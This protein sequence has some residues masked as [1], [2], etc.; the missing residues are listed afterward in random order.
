MTLPLVQSGHPQLQAPLP[1][2][3]ALGGP[4]G[5]LPVRPPS[6]SRCIQYMLMS[7]GPLGKISMHSAGLCPDCAEAE[8]FMQAMQFICLGI[9]EPQ[10][11]SCRVE[12]ARAHSTQPTLGFCREPCTEMGS[13]ASHE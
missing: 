12:S 7:R 9:L 6:W 8:C 10:Q 4:S 2:C 11:S 5:Q 1:G 13:M 3:L